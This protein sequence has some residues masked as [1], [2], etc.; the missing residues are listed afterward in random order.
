VHA[1]HGLKDQ[2]GVYQLQILTKKGGR[3]SHTE[4]PL[5][6]S[7]CQPLPPPRLANTAG[8]YL[9][10]PSEERAKSAEEGGRDVAVST[11]TT[12]WCALL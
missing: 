10:N 2:N 7:S 4:A 11:K 5:M 3:K 6:S 1:D 9:P 8:F 12:S